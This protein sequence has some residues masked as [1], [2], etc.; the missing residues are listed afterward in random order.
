MIGQWKTFDA[1]RKLRKVEKSLLVDSTSLIETSEFF[2]NGQLKKQGIA[3][4]DKSGPSP[5]FYLKGEWTYFLENGT[6][7]KKV[8]YEN[9]WGVMTTYADGKVIKS[10]APPVV[11]PKKPQNQ[12]NTRSGVKMIRKGNEIITIQYKENGDSTVQITPVKPLN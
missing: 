1:N 12:S 7:D 6:P 9:G 11:L 10:P 8:L 4:L 3:V 2:Q 5:R